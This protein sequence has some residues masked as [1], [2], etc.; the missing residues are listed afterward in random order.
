MEF[1]YS[2]TLLTVCAQI[3]YFK[4]QSSNLKTFQFLEFLN[5]NENPI[6]EKLNLVHQYYV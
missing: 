6:E 2:D 3:M 4:G 1:H 5:L